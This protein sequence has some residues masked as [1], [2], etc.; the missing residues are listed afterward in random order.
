MRQSFFVDF[1]HVPS[2]NSLTRWLTGSYLE[3]S[4]AGDLDMRNEFIDT[5]SSEHLTILRVLDLMNKK[6]DD[7]ATLLRDLRAELFDVVTFD[8]QDA[9][10]YNHSNN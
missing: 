1:R 3:T 5:E 7:Q 10:S 9:S 4:L 8:V 6:L 2:Y